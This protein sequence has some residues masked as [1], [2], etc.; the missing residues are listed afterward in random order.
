MASRWCSARVGSEQREREETGGGG[1]REESEESRADEKKNVCEAQD[2]VIGFMDQQRNAVARLADA[3]EG[4]MVAFTDQRDMDARLAVDPNLG[5]GETEAQ[6]A[7]KYYKL[8]I[9]LEATVGEVL[10]S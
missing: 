10:R 1:G 5:P 9:T 6:A 3:M 8:Q 2:A 4:L 7:R